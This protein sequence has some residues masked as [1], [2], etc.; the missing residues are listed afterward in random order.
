MVDKY[1]TVGEDE[2]TYVEGEEEGEVDG[3]P[4]H[5]DDMDYEPSIAPEGEGDA[6]HEPEPPDPRGVL[7]RLTSIRQQEVKRT[8]LRLH[9]NLGHPTNAELARILESKNASPELVEAARI[10]ECPVCH[11]HQRPNSVPVSSIPKTTSFNERVQADTLWVVPPGNIRAVPVLMMSDAMT[12]LISAR[13]LATED[14]EEFIKSVEK[15]WIRSFGPMK[16]LQVDE[17]RAW[18]S[19]K[20]RNWCSENGIELIISPG[21]SHSRLAILERRHQ[22]TRRALTLSS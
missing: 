2:N 20:V 10:H 22:V 15:G 5:D 13:L 7:Y 16:I 11:Q 9:R 19:E 18:S 21:Q 4:P 12:R 8:L 1:Y 6:P 17:H 14:S 3:D